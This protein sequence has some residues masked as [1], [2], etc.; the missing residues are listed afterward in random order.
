MK[1]DREATAVVRHTQADF[2]RLFPGS[3]GAIYGWPTH[4][5]MGSF[6]RSAAATRVPGLFCAGGTVHPGPGIPMVTLSGRIAA[7]EVR[8]YLK[9]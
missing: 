8:R 1:L 3:D 7:S 6:K 4:G 2:D 5:W 9:E